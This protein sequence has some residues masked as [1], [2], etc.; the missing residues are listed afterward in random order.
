MTRS[1]RSTGITPLH[2]YKETALSAGI[3]LGGQVFG[4]QWFIA[5]MFH[6]L[7][8]YSPLNNSYYWG[9]GAMGGGR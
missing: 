1:L 7:W 3:A 6:S 2:H 5:S 4:R 8:E 9:G